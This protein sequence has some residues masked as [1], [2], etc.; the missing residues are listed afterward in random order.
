[1]L[2]VDNGNEDLYQYLYDKYYRLV[3]TTSYRIL[4]NNE[5]CE[6]IAQ[7]AFRIGFRNMHK[8]K[9][10]DH[11]RNYILKITY[12]MAITKAKDNK[13]RHNL[14]PTPINDEISSDKDIIGEAVEDIYITQILDELSIIDKEVILLHSQ[15]YKL[16]EIAKILGI[17]LPYTKVKLHRTR[18]VLWEKMEGAVINEARERQS[19]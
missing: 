3:Y 15:G 6:E 9:D 14:F 17:S 7:D 8:L 1:M 19:V 5:D 18:K 12:N 4:N 16:K 13:N 2:K 11:F 10:T